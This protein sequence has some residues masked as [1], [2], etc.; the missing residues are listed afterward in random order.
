MTEST[1][2]D[3]AAST[4]DLR[5]L[6]HEEVRDLLSVSRDKLDAMRKDA[7]L[8]FPAAVD[9]GGRLLRWRAAD[10]RAWFDAR[11]VPAVAA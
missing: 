6:T 11:T 9:L 2:R 8:R 5:L 10:I 7:E 4:A 3:S 1:T